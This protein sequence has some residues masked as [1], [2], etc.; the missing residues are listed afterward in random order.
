M[1]VVQESQTAHDQL[2]Q[3]FEMSEKRRIQLQQT[4]TTLTTQLE[5]CMQTSTSASCCLDNS[6]LADELVCGRSE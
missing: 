3:S 2:Q 5:V 4:L 1:A 6:I